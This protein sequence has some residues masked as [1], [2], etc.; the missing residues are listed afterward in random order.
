MYTIFIRRGE[1]GY[2]RNKDEAWEKVQEKVIYFNGFYKFFV[3]KITIRNTKSRWG[4]CSKLGNL[5]FNYKIAFLPQRLID[6]LVVHELCHLKEFNHSKNF[7]SLVSK[8]I[9]HWRALRKEIKL[10]SVSPMPN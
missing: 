9:P 5:S 4:S 10:V 7:W 6:Y 1:G 8:T 2:K 3:G